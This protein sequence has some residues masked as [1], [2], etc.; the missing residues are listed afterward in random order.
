M[1][2][3]VLI[4]TSGPTES[5]SPIVWVTETEWGHLLCSRHVYLA[6]EMYEVG[7]G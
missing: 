5:V 6:A 1:V 3:A 4:S 7:S 2:T